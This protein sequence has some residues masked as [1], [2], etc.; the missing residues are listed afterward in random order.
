MTRKRYQPSAPADVRVESDGTQWTLI[1][2]RQLSHPPERVWS[3]LTSP[4]ELQQWAPFN[5]ERDLAQPGS[6]TLTMAGP[7]PEALPAE[8]RRADAPR[9]LEYTWGEDTLRWEL[10][11]SGTG[12]RLVLRHTTKERGTVPM[13]AAGWHICLDVAERWLSG[14]PV[15]RIV[16]DEAKDYG[17]EELNR[18][19]TQRLG[20]AGESPPAQPPV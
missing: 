12:T 18:V 8:V 6:L 14:D 16:A 5:A 20:V 10:A 15:G 19:Y 7:D 11:P 2:T 3:A 9:L 13:A 17:W 4:A 1:F